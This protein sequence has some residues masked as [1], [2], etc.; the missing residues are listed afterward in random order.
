MRITKHI[1]ILLGMLLLMLGSAANA[2][3]PPRISWTPAQLTPASMAPGTSTSHTVVLKHTGIL[4]IPFTN[5]LR[6]V[7]EGA[8][9]PFVTIAQPKFPALFKRGNQVTFQV[10]ITLPANTPAGEIK[11]SL[12][13]KRIL[14]GKE[15][16]VWRADPLPISVQVVAAPSGLAPPSD[17]QVIEIG[18]GPEAIAVNTKVYE[19]QVDLPPSFGLTLDS[20]HIES[21]ISGASPISADGRFTA[22]MNVEATA[23]LRVVDN[24]GNG[25]LLKLYPK[26]EGLVEEN[27]VIDA[28][29]TAIALMAIQPGIITTD[30]YIDA[31]IIAIMARLPEMQALSLQ[32]S[33]ELS[34]GT[35][36]VNGQFSAEILSAMRNASRAL[37]N[38]SPQDVY[39]FSISDKLET[40]I[41]R[42]LNSV[43]SPAFAEISF[44]DPCADI[45]SERFTGKL[46]NQDG[47]CI[48]AEI[49]D[50]EQVSTFYMS[51]PKTRWVFF[52]IDEGKGDINFIDFIPPRHIDFPNSKDLLLDGL[53]D[54]GILLAD[55][56][57]KKYELEKFIERYYQRIESRFG[58]AKSKVPVTF[59]SN[60]IY[61]LKTVGFAQD[62]L[63]VLPDLKLDV[64]KAYIGSFGLTVFT[65]GVLPWIS[66]VK[67]VRPPPLTQMLGTKGVLA[68][69]N[70]YGEWISRMTTNYAK[71]LSGEPTAS[72]F[73]DWF[74]KDFLAEPE[75]YA[76][77]GCISHESIL[78]FLK[79][80]NFSTELVNI[81]GSNIFLI[82]KVSAIA[83]AL[84]NNGLMLEAF[85]DPYLASLDVY[86]AKVGNPPPPNTPPN[87]L[88][89]SSTAQSGVPV[90]INVLDNDKDADGDI[91]TIIDVTQGTKGGEV[92]NNTSSVTYTSTPGFVGT[93]SFTYT[94]SDGFYNSK[95]TVTV[96][97][98]YVPPANQ[99]P[100]AENDTAAAQSGIPLQID[101]LNK[102]SDPDGDELMVTEVNNLSNGSVTIASDRKSVTY[103]S[104]AGFV[105]T[106][107]FTY[108]ISDG[109]GGS[110]TATV[111]VTV[112]AIAPP[113]TWSIT[114]AS[115]SVSE[116]AGTVSFT[117]SRTNST[118]AKT[119]YVS[120]V[121]DQGT[122]NNGDYVGKLN[123]P[124]P[125]AAGQA[126]QAVTV[127]IN[128]DTIVEGN[129]TFRL[130]VQESTTDPIN[131]SVASA[132]FTILDSGTSTPTGKLNDT[133]I[134]SCADATTNRL[135]CPVT[136]FP[137][138]DAQFGRDVTHNDDSD[139]HAGFSFTKL[140]SNGNPLPANASAWDCVKDNVTGLIWEVKTTSGLRSM[141]NTYTWYEPDN[142]KNGG[143]AGTQNGGS[144]T[145]SAC[146]TQ[147]YV[148]AVNAQGLC[149]AS[150]WRMPDRNELLSIV[151]NSRF[152]PAIDTGYF[153]NTP[154]SLVWSSSPYAYRSNGVWYVFFYYGVDAF[155]YKT[156]SGVRVRL[157]RGGQ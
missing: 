98:S 114:P 64:D 95:A 32:I 89:D 85:T 46:G 127:T 13:L 67:D 51:N 152:N 57:F 22:R 73:A 130:I 100:I 31:V 1:N 70:S 20:L 40:L 65:E 142:S 113:T 30:P 37:A 122:T 136:G 118:A 131:T 128:K 59:S 56:V 107:A 110:D 8:I 44:A 39:T 50:P 143:S 25:Y 53:K 112:T 148:Q 77:A 101:V 49:A 134:T 66:V 21:G 153:P 111:T 79:I 96:T 147:G 123:E 41:A 155:I 88:D 109:K 80:E 35:F 33:N 63:N 138:Q 2:A 38:I 17:P 117:I 84:I 7:A 68:C 106:D 45:F 115:V 132:T 93:D 90:S 29:S 48:G 150:D 42:W 47:V 15:T 135:A 116:S 10:T 36:R 82:D 121:Q 120:T 27:P 3:L 76:F 78:T 61:Q 26:E 124:V 91:K 92:K 157:V 55:I 16:E 58:P 144:C 18:S 23:L 86:T 14:N 139:G 28:E 99:D 149:G 105:G 145:G 83:D 54:T 4:P 69:I 154:A 9:A 140:D 141:N 125:F 75:A 43:V 102:D 146:D 126:Q 11:G 52:G 71:I 24:E 103:K 12:L 156:Y 137:G 6:I 97:V 60:G 81:F 87:A 94:I 34:N 62:R 119:V 129:E 72:K 133:G 74:V 108:T 151:D 19:G 5:Q 104:N